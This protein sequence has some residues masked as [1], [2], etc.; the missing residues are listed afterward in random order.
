MQTTLSGHTTSISNI[1]TSVNGISSQWG[2]SVN[3]N[4]RVTGLM[5]N[6]GADSKTT[7][8]V[9]V[10]NFALVDPSNTSHRPFLYSNNKFFM[11]AQYIDITGVVNVINAGGA[12]TQITGAGI[13]A[14]EITADKLASV[15]SITSS[16]RSPN[17]VTPASLGGNT[18]SAPVGF[19]LEGAPFQTHYIDGTTDN[20]NMEIGTTANMGGHPVSE[21]LGGVFN[22]S[23]S[24]TTPGLFEW[25]CPKGV[26]WVNVVAV[27]AGGGGAPGD[28]TYGC[29]GGGGGGAAVKYT[30]QVVPGQT[31][32][33]RV[34]VGGQGGVPSDANYSGYNG[35]PSY[36]T[37][38]FKTVNYPYVIGWDTYDVNGVT[39]LLSGAKTYAQLGISKPTSYS[40]SYPLPWFT[41]GVANGGFGGYKR[42]GGPGGGQETDAHTLPYSTFVG[43]CMFVAPTAGGKPEGVSPLGGAND[44]RYAALGASISTDAGYARADG[45]TLQSLYGVLMGGGAGSLG[46]GVL[47]DSMASLITTN[48]QVWAHHPT[49]AAMMSWDIVSNGQYPAT[50]SGSGGASLFCFGP[51]G[52][53]AFGLVDHNSTPAQTYLLNSGVTYATLVDNLGTTPKV[54]C[55]I[56]GS[57]PSNNYSLYNLLA[58]I[59]GRG[60]LGFPSSNTQDSANASLVNGTAG[61]PG[62]VLL[63]W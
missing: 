35:E 5:L 55:L 46:A 17:Y 10:D 34:G 31:Y 25:V 47:D 45:T 43:N 42:A 7:F 29:G 49:R 30:I 54:T 2:V 11:D 16:L 19:R 14:G 33:V 53:S 9:M 26:F 56:P 51:T 6:S 44:A 4:G 23:K 3:N 37:P 36:F 59:G 21:V 48:A 1:Q 58:G 63:M 8:A 12:S 52:I 27:G 28:P 41:Q 57:T 13:K 50:L 39:N 15:L 60:G 61:S 20:V 18:W 40:P 38:A 24:F 32:L 62:A 22:K